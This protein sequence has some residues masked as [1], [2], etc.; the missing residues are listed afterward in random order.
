MSQVR[1]SACAI[2][3]VRAELN[4]IEIFLIIPAGE[5]EALEQ[6]SKYDQSCLSEAL[7]DVRTLQLDAF[8]PSMTG[9]LNEYRTSK[10]SP[11][12][13][14]GCL[15]PR[16]VAQKLGRHMKDRVTTAQPEGRKRSPRHSMPSSP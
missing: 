11:W 4:R 1:K 5:K 9:G 16:M 3:Q 2:E 13:A 8:V 14:N 6:L 10:L 12:L 15:S 7:V